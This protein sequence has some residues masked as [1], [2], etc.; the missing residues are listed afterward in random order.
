MEKEK[1][2]MSG[3]RTNKQFDF[4]LV[5]VALESVACLLS[6]MKEGKI[7]H[8]AADKKALQSFSE[9]LCRA[10]KDLALEG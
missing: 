9:K 7:P 10:Y 5:A 2:M 6:N 4:R 1:M 8:D 3:E